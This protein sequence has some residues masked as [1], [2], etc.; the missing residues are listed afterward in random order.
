VKK[1]LAEVLNAFLEP[2]RQ[3]RAELEREPERVKR[4]LRDGTARA[5]AVAE[6]TLFD[7]KK[8][9]KY[10]FFSRELKLG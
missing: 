8:A 2:M 1:R 9:M 6:E 4:V 3:H 10:D 7:A 5:N